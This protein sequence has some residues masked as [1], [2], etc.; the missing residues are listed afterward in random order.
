MGHEGNFIQ[1]RLTYSKVQVMKDDFNVIGSDLAHHF[2][3]TLFKLDI[4][5]YTSVLDSLFVSLGFR[6]PSD[7]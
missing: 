5:S 7:Q 2:M 3:E 6:R 4:A 1:N